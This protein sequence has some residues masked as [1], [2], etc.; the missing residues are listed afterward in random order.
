MRRIRTVAPERYVLLG[1]LLAAAALWTAILLLPPPAL[2]VTAFAVGEGDALLIRAPSGRAL[3]IDGGSRTLPDVGARV[4][5]PNLLLAGV[6][7]LDAILITHPDSDH[8]NALP[9]VLNTLPVDMLLDP[10][11]PCET[12]TYRRL[13]AKAE[14]KR[15]PRYR[16]R[17]GDTLN[18]G[19]GVQLRILAPA[20]QLVGGGEDNE[21]S[22]VCLL[23][24]KNARMLF[25]GDLEG[26]GE[27]ALL[28]RGADV[29]ADVLKVAHHGSRNATS[30]AFLAAVDPTWALI[31]TRGDAS[32][33]LAPVMARLRKRGVQVLRTDAHGQIRLRTDGQRWR[34]TTFLQ[35]E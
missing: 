32:R 27:T 33:D 6:R 10:D 15:V 11:L 5:A 34:V 7:K 9:A 26:A 13:L 35:G 14:Q 30:E 17:A 20:E 1:L 2:E 29:R 24:M 3:L 23:E 22:V 12:D 31:S 8:I 25:T 4:L 28:E 18:L 19:S 21:N 16:V